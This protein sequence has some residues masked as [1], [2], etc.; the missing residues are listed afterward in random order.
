MIGKLFQGKPPAAAAPAGERLY[1]VGD[2]HGCAGL[3]TQLLVKI[4]AD[5]GDH[6]RRLVFLGDYV[7][8]GEDSKAVIDTL[9]SIRS[10]AP[11]TIFLRGNHEQAVLDFLEAPDRNEDWLHWGGDKTLESY[12]IENIW[13]QSPAALAQALAHRMPDAHL[14]FLKSLDLW[15]VLGDYAFVHAGFKPGVAMADQSEQDC[16]WIRA[17][18]HNAPVE[19]RPKE[20][21]VHGHH[22]V[23]KPLDL[24]WR[25]AVDTGAVW[26]DALTAV[27][28]DGSARR[29]ISTR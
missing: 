6:K 12:G 29:F 19:G 9:L 3:L 22:P 20:V 1:A 8:R 7:D 28:L 15:R 27:V 24:G 13:Q 11:E 21:V 16:L 23:K 18:F 4:D 5:S 17:E 14:A 10:R 25:I 2:I 26:S